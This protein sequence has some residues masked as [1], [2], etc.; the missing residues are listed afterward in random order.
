[1]G[2]VV[3]YH[4]CL[5]NGAM[6]TTRDNSIDE[7][8]AEE[9]FGMGAI[10]KIAIQALWEDFAEGRMTEW[11]EETETTETELLEAMVRLTADI[12][13]SGKI[14]MYRTMNGW[15]TDTDAQVEAV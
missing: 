3:L 5:Y 10:G 2:G 7:I 13:S 9:Y 12:V 11:L 1:M 4:F 15:E 6:T 14:N 8:L